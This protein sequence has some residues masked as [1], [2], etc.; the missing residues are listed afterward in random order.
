MHSLGKYCDHARSFDARSHPPSL[1]RGARV[2]G[3]DEN[4]VE[5]TAKADAQLREAFAEFRSVIDEA[6]ADGDPEALES[7]LRGIR[8]IL[9]RLEGSVLDMTAMLVARLRRLD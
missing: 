1:P 6:L 3:G 8:A 9:D 2:T 5:E 7:A 4:V